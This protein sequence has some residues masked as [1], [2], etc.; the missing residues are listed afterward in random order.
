VV[1]LFDVQ[2]DAASTKRAFRIEPSIPGAEVEVSGNGLTMTHASDFTPHTGYTVTIAS[3]AAGATG[4]AMGTTYSFGFRTGG[5]PPPPPPVAPTVDF[6]PED[7]ATE[8][9]TDSPLR[10][11]FS[12]PM[13]SAS[14]E[15]ALTIDPVVTI[16]W[17]WEDGGTE[18]VVRPEGGWPAGTIITVTL[19]PT[20]RDARG[21]P[22]ELSRQSAFGTAAAAIGPEDPHPPDPLVWLGRLLASLAIALCAVYLVI[23]NRRARE[24]Q[25]RYQRLLARAAPS[26][27]RSAAARKAA[28]RG[29][30][31]G[32]AP[33]RTSCRS[34]LAREMARRRIAERD[35][36]V[37]SLAPASRG[38]KV[39]R[40]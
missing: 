14:V 26:G 21:I 5:T 23:R 34:E 10:L 29:S 37:Y 36:R 4:V 19:D 39:P 7:G 27:Q 22:M 8:V 32:S 12:S 30:S 11:I 38:E 25:A 3:D 16:T 31:S 24:E 6:I 18:M 15:D 2:M 35:G 9:P 17:T 28:R 20:A 40:P 1:V 13:D 33:A